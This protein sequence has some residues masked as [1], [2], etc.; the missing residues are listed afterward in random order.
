M[1]EGD[2]ALGEEFFDFFCGEASINHDG[3]VIC[4]DNRGVTGTTTTEDKKTIGHFDI[5]IYSFGCFA[6]KKWRNRTNGE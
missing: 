4:L 3:S 1:V 6:N 2:I 5:G